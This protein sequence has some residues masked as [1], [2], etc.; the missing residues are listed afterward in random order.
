MVK[1]RPSSSSS[2][3]SLP[4]TRRI[5]DVSSGEDSPAYSCTHSD[6]CGGA[7]RDRPGSAMQRRYGMGKGKHCERR[8]RLA[9]T[10]AQIREA[11][12]ASHNRTEKERPSKTQTVSCMSPLPLL[13]LRRGALADTARDQQGS[14]VMTRKKH[15]D[16]VESVTSRR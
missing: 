14:S 15:A 8:E 7:F 10:Q 16:K 6:T 13:I 2:S 4:H 12:G 3:R 9:F 1:R 5:G 11:E